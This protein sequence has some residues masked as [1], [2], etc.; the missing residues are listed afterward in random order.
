MKMKQHLLFERLIEHFL[1][2]KIISFFVQARQSH[3]SHSFW[4]KG[5]RVARVLEFL[6]I[7][8]VPISGQWPNREAF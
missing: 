4:S 3:L 5:K 2:K 7:K 6:D 1:K 8:D